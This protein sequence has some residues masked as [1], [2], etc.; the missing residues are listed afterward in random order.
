MHMIRFFQTK[1]SLKIQFLKLLG[2]WFSILI[3]SVTSDVNTLLYSLA[4][5]KLISSI[6]GNEKFLLYRI[7]RRFPQGPHQ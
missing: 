1:Y 2:L 7:C 3:V 4:I 5:D 6:T